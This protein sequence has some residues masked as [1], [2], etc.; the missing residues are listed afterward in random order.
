MPTAIMDHSAKLDKNLK[1]QKFQITKSN[2][3]L[4]IE[5]KHE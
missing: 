2:E 3:R 4:N 5:N 1:N